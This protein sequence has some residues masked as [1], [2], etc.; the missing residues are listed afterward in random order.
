MIDLLEQ[1][2]LDIVKGDLAINR[3]KYGAL[4]GALIE[5]NTLGTQQLM[6][7]KHSV[8]HILETITHL[9]NKEPQPQPLLNGHMANLLIFFIRSPTIKA[10][11]IDLLRYWNIYLHIM[12]EFDAH[13]VSGLLEDALDRS[14]TS[15]LSLTL[16][17]KFNIE[18]L[19]ECIKASKAS[20]DDILKPGTDFS[21]CCILLEIFSKVLSS[22]ELGIEYLSP[23]IAGSRELLVHIARIRF[24]NMFQLRRLKSENIDLN[25]DHRDLCFCQLVDQWVCILWVPHSKTIYLDMQNI[26]ISRESEPTIT[27]DNF[28]V[29]LELKRASL[30]PLFYGYLED[31]KRFHT[32][33]HSRVLESD[34]ITGMKRKYQNAFRDQRMYEEV[35]SSSPHQKNSLQGLPTQLWSNDSQQL[36]EDSPIVQVKETP[37]EEE[38]INVNQMDSCRNNLQ[39][40]FPIERIRNNVARLLKKLRILQLQ[41]Q[42][43]S[44][45]LTRDE[46]T[47]P[48]EKCV[49]ARSESEMAAK[50]QF[51]K[52]VQVLIGENESLLKIVKEVLSRGERIQKDLYSLLERGSTRNSELPLSPKG[53]TYL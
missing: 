13:L 48:S 24:K 33:E 10:T 6:R 38:D 17:K 43:S 26:A 31:V 42:P 41:V 35:L 36:R 40:T 14:R 53:T 11:N 27:F 49:N 1:L 3:T 9:Q 52:T 5:K 39:F 22:Q 29:Q 16:L 21:S 37:R 25:S 46:N 34:M 2:S 50:H 4:K 44:P 12:P 15:W 20:A 19:H 51:E 32:M 28:K 7:I 8:I 45:P 47:K 18:D 23:L 30:N